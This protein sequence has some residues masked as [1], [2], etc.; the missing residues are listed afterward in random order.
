[1]PLILLIPFTLMGIALV[2]LLVY[3]L[4]VATRTLT[5]LVF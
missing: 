1:M 3:K 2:L 5:S 4:I